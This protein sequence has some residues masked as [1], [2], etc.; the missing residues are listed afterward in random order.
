MDG[1]RMHDCGGRVGAWLAKGAPYEH[2]L[3]YQ[4]RDLGL[5]GTAFD[6]GAHVGNHAL[7]LASIGLKVHAWEP[8]EPSRR[9]LYS[10]LELNPHLSVTVHPW[11]AGDRDTYGRFTKGMWLEFDPFRDGATMK[12]DRG[13][14]PVHPIDGRLNV[15]DLAVVK[16]DVEGM[17]PHVL[18]GMRQT[19]LA[20]LPV[21]Y[22]ETHDPEAELSQRAVL[23][24]LGYT[25]AETI[26]MGSPVTRWMP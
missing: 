14:I 18:R 13:D 15:D 5:S 25:L 11:A 7:Y 6:V 3:L 24:P 23:E 22:C 10:N 12:V 21:V 26:K 2:K 17:E 4:I 1:Y 20:N 16:I 19:L 9:I 8:H